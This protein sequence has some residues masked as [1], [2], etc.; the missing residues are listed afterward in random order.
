MLHLRPAQLVAGPAAIIGVR[1]ET[2][3]G[4]P[5][6]AGTLLVRAGNQPRGPPDHSSL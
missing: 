2:K 5:C 4:Q 1:S 3:L 6:P